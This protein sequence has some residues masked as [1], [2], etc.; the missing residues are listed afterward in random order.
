MKALLAYSTISQLGLMI[1]LYGL[2][3]EL[4]TAAATMHLLCHAVFK[5]ALFLVAGSIE[6]NVGTR[7]I[8]SLD[9]LAYLMPGLAAVAAVVALS[10]A[11]YRP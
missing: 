4:A 8:Y 10:L 6:Y 7:E 2:G 1:A 9:G 3:T 5:G 11:A